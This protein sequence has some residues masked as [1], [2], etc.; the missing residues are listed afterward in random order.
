[1]FSYQSLGSLEG[2]DPAQAYVENATTCGAFSQTAVA[3]NGGT[4]YGN[5]VSSIYD[6]WG[7]DTYLVGPSGASGATITSAD[8]VTDFDC[9]AFSSSSVSANGA[10]SNANG[11]AVATIENCD[12]WDGEFEPTGIAQ[13]GLEPV[14]FG[15][16]AS[17]T[18]EV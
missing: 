18:S 15:C 6:C 3:A 11:G 16:S 10:G 14:P 9:E 7:G 2:A 13:V 5:S 8:T 1:S 12:A 17:A 4:A